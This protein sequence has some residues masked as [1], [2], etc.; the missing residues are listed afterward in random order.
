[1]TPL[2]VSSAIVPVGNRLES[3]R[4]KYGERK[5]HLSPVAKCGPEVTV[6]HCS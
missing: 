5:Q 6:G 1:M 4:G 2:A 3:Y